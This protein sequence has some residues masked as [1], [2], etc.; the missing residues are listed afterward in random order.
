VRGLGI[1]NTTI[2]SGNELVPLGSYTPWRQK[3]L[4][5][6]DLKYSYSIVW[7][8]IQAVVGNLTERM[9]EPQNTDFIVEDGKLWIY[10]LCCIRS[11]NS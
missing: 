9:I 10:G 11:V 1:I 5:L 4:E 2:G 8:Q 7:D 6:S 3:S